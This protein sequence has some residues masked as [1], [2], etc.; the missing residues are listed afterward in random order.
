[1]RRSQRGLP[2]PGAH[3]APGKGG[4]PPSKEPRPRAEGRQVGLALGHP[5]GW[6]RLL[7]QLPRTRA[8]ALPSFLGCNL[9]APPGQGSVRG[10]QGAPAHRPAGRTPWDPS[11]GTHSLGT[12]PAQRQ[13]P[14][15]LAKPDNGSVLA[16]RRPEFKKTGALRPRASAAG[17]GSPEL[18]KSARPGPQRPIVQREDVNVHFKYLL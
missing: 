11:T 1:M 4:V 5:L 15:G 7:G 13:G 3:A 16:Q 14:T 8:S 2:G 17:R 9:P 18:I 12:R 6:A 10:L